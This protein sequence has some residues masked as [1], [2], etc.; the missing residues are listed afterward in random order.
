MLRFLT[1][2][3]LKTLLIGGSALTSLVLI[4]T[5]SM[6]QVEQATRAADPARI[7]QDLLSDKRMPELERAVEV[8][9]AAPLNAPAGAED[10]KFSLT[11]L[12][13]DGVGIYTAE[14]LDPIYREKL[15]TTVSLA[16][17]YGIAN[18]LTTKYRNDGY[19][20]TQVVVPPQTIENGVVKLRVVE[21]FVDQINIQ[22]NQTESEMKQ[23]RKYAENLKEN[24]I[25][26]AKKMEKYLLLINDLPGVKARSILS[27]SKTKPGAS[28]MTIII[29]S[30]TYDAEVGINNHGSRYLGPYQ[31]SYSGVLNSILGM[32]EKITTDITVSGD[33]HRPNELMFGGVGYT[34]PI[35]RYGTKV[36]FFGGSSA[37][38]PGADLDQFDVQG[39]AYIFSA[40][41]THPFIRSRTTNWNGRLSF[42][43]ANVTS[44]NDLEPNARKDRIRSLRLGTNYQFIDTLIGFGIN[45]ID[46]EYSQGIDVFG[47]SDAGSSK[48]TRARGEPNYKKANFDIQRLQRVT[49][50]INI[51]FAGQGQWAATPLLSAEEFGVGGMKIGRGYDNSEIVGDDGI[52]GKIEV[53]WRQPQ[54]FKYINDYT[55]FA[56]LDSG[57]VWDQDATTSAGKRDSLTSIGLGINADITDKITTGFG[58][59]LPLTREVEVKNDKEPRF[60]FNIGHKF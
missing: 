26:D 45:S 28:D 52:A 39:R 22:G 47:A 57:R 49:S 2:P 58:V 51:L 14:D 32:N 25:L 30:H 15:G 20:L 6:A 11:S 53:Q 9:D 23:I 18:T 7:T 16:D 44:K 54:A 29:E 59:S 19:I 50:S 41:L 40:G 3:T 5:P 55:L 33:K 13:I 8:T 43:A 37:S 60:Y 10:I 38:Q 35:N 21:G 56:H 31:A 27:P 12:Q 24:N 4:S 42:D 46:L 34:Q 48:L 36:S 17:M 1:K